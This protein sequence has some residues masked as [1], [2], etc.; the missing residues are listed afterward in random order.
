ML[1]PLPSVA[2]VGPLKKATVVPKV[3][4]VKLYEY[5][6]GELE[7][8]Q[9]QYQSVFVGMC[10]AIAVVAFSGEELAAPPLKI[11]ERT[12]VTAPVVGFIDTNSDVLGKPEA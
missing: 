8:P 6:L 9:E 7:S 12:I 2:P 11:S 4:V 3:L 1:L 5:I 10:K